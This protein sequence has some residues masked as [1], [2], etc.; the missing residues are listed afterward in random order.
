MTSGLKIAIQSVLTQLKAIPFDWTTVPESTKSLPT[1][2]FQKVLMW[3]DQVRRMKSGQGYTFEKPACFLE[4]EHTNQQM[5]TDGISNEDIVWK[6]HI[7]DMQLDAGDEIGLDENLSVI[8]YRDGIIK[9]FARFCPPQ[10]STMFYVDERPDYE[11]SD[12][13]HYVVSLKSNFTDTKASDIDPDQTLVLYKEPDTNLEL[14]ASFYGIDPE[15]I[16]IIPPVMVKETYYLPEFVTSGMGTT[17]V[18][19]ELFN[20]D[21]ISVVAETFPLEIGV[22]VTLETVSSNGV[23]TFTPVLPD[24]QHVFIIYKK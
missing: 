7:V 20:A 3:N 9:G 15:E 1:I 6:F 2:I 11:H 13:Y 18:F 8:D 16:I 10:C 4:L 12:V 22:D 14:D 5:F 21:L 23:L 19:T 17:Y 24:G